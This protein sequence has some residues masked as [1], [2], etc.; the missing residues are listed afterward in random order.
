MFIKHIKKTRLLVEIELLFELSNRYP[1]LPL[2]E[3]FHIY[4]SP[5]ILLDFFTSLYFILGLESGKFTLIV[6]IARHH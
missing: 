1:P 4:S 3:K 2:E 6:Y 5:C